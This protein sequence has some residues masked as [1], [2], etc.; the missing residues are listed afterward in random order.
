MFGGYS[1][2]E[3]CFEVVKSLMPA[4]GTLLEIGSGAVTSEFTKHFE[5]FSIEED[6]AY[7]GLA[8]MSHYIHA[9][10]VDGWYDR[11]VLK[12]SLPEIYHVLLVDGP[13]TRPDAS[14]MGFWEN[15]DLFNLSIP[16]VFDDINRTAPREVFDRIGKL[17]GS[18]GSVHVGKQKMFG[19]YG[20][21]A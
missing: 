17:I 13:K 19:V 2:D 6:V 5:V 1:I 4:G 21:A 15:R 11:S 3:E 20:E 14:R 9:P 8:E 18:E 16:M 10:I 7:L 12:S